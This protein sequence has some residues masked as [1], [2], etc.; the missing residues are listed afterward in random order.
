[1]THHPVSCYTWMFTLTWW[2]VPLGDSW[3]HIP[4]IPHTSLIHS[5]FVKKHSVHVHV[6]ISTKSRGFRLYT[7]YAAFSPSRGS[8]GTDIA[9]EGV[10]LQANQVIKTTLNLGF[11]WMS[12]CSCTLFSRSLFYVGTNSKFLN[13]CGRTETKPTSVGLLTAYHVLC[14]TADGYIRYSGSRL[15]VYFCNATTATHTYNVDTDIHLVRTFTFRTKQSLQQSGTPV[16]ASMSQSCLKYDHRY[17]FTQ[18]K[19]AI[20]W[21]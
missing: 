11:P 17:I 19:L 8:V 2:M 7:L 5:I 15:Q 20:F 14:S 12:T 16:E 21:L 4:T 13:S 18:S 9:S 3:G 10:V 6:H 1:M